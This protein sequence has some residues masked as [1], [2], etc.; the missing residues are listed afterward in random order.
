VWDCRDEFA[1]P[2]EL[3]TGRLGQLVSD[4]VAEIERHSHHPVT[5]QHVEGRVLAQWPA[6]SAL[7]IEAPPALSHRVFVRWDTS[8]TVDGAVLLEAHTDLDMMFPQRAYR[9]DSGRSRAVTGENPRRWSGRPGRRFPQASVRRCAEVAR[10]IACG[11]THAAGHAGSSVRHG[12]G[13]V[14]ATA[15]PPGAAA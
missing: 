6:I 10:A 3:H 14:C 15:C 2:I 13:G 1:S 7:S 12:G 5:R 11:R 4:R 9:Q 8:S